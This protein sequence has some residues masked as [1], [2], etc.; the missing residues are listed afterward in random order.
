MNKILLIGN[1]TK[2]VELQEKDGVNYV[3]FTLAVNHGLEKDGKKHVDFF[4]C[5]AFHKQ[6]EVLAKYVKKGAKLAIAAYL[7][8]ARYG[9]DNALQWT[10][11][12]EEFDLLSFPPS[13]TEKPTATADA[14]PF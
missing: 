12:I 14:L 13:D 11:F 9:K 10:A 3:R 1:I 4:T 6:A 8:S 7:T 5:V 2:D